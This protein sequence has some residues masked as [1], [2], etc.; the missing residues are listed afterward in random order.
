MK[1]LQLPFNTGGSTGAPM[2][3]LVLGRFM[4]PQRRGKTSMDAA[5]R[6]KLVIH[7]SFA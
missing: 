3:R 6:F 2:A 1:A 4:F 5:L 7:H